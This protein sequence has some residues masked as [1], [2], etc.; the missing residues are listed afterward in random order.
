[1]N[2]NES[3]VPLA[4]AL[5]YCQRMRDL[6]RDDTDSRQYASSVRV[7]EFDTFDSEYVT[8]DHRIENR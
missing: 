4:Y 1:M 3:A 6:E 7:L 5:D 2:V 8:V